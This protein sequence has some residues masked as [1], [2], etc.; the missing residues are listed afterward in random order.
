MRR[1]VAFINKVEIASSQHFTPFPFSSLRSAAQGKSWE[2]ASFL[3]FLKS[4]FPLA[5]SPFRLVNIYSEHDKH[6]HQA[7]TNPDYLSTTQFNHKHHPDMKP[8]AI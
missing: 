5:G 1:V 2:H 3:I 6:H 4:A 7:K 8:L